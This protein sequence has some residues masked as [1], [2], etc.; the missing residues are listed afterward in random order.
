[1]SKL[2]FDESPLVILPSLA[3]MIGLNES[4]ILQQIHYWITKKQGIIHE[5]KQ[6]IYNSIKSWNEQFPFFSENTIRRTIEN[7]VKLKILDLKQLSEDKRDRT[8]YYSI[9]YKELENSTNAFTQNGRMDV[10]NLGKPCNQNEQMTIYTEN[11]TKITTE[12]IS[13]K[14]A[15]DK[16]E[17]PNDVSEQVWQDYLSHRKLKKASISKTVIE[18]LRVEAMKAGI[19]LEE[20][21]SYSIT[22][23]WQ[24]FKSDWVNK[25][26]KPTEKETNMDRYIKRLQEEEERKG[27]N[28]IENGDF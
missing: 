23:G 6:W 22:M 2:L 12:N 8:N 1:M 15:F 28:I 5:N 27:S 13:A 11:T 10:T 25:T 17:K 7:L 16:L 19:S 3:K 18:S 24:G 14:R 20:A 26:S 9:N 4:I 21:M